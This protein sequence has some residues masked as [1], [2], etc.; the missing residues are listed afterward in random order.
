MALPGAMA[1]ALSSP[2]IN[3]T[4]PTTPV[5]AS[6]KAKLNTMMTTL[7]SGKAALDSYAAKPAASP[8]TSGTIVNQ[9]KGFTT[10]RNGNETKTVQTGQ[11]DTEAPQDSQTPEQVPNKNLQPGAQGEDVKK[12][13]D[14]LV[15]HGYLTSEQVATGPGTYGKQTTAAVA[16]LQQEL[17]LNPG[18]ASGFYGPQTQQAQGMQQK[19]AAA[20]KQLSGSDAPNNPSEGLGAMQNATQDQN[21]TDPTLG[22][23]ASNLQPT[24]D[25]LNQVLKNNSNP[26]L[27]AISLQKEYTNLMQQYDVPELQADLMNVQK[28]MEGTEDDIRD[29]VTKTGGFAT[30]SQ[31]MALSAARNKVLLKNYNALASQHQAAQD[32]VN[33]MMKFATEDRSMAMQR[34]NLVASVSEHLASIENQKTQMGMTMEN[35][36][37]DDVNKIVTNIGYTGLA[38]QARGN[39]DMLGY[40]EHTLKLVPGSLSNPASLQQLETYRQQQLAQG[41]QKINISVGAG[42]GSTGIPSTA[43]D[44]QV[45]Y[46]K[47]TGTVPAFGYGVAG[48]SARNAFWNAVASSGEGTIAGASGNKAALAAATTA[49]R[50]QTNQYNAANT[51]LSTLDKQLSLLEQYSDKVDRSGTPAFNRYQLYMKGQLQGDPDTQALQNIVLTASNEFAKILSGSAASISGTTVSSAED[52]KKLLNANMTTAQMKAVIGV[53]RQE[54][55][56]RLQ[57]QKETMTQIQNDIK[58]INSGGSSYTQGKQSDSDFIEKSLSGQNIKYTDVINGATGNEIPAVNRSTGAV[59]YLQPNEFDSSQFIRL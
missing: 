57:S 53:M 38:A 9:G 50:N 28:V 27:Q 26:A 32:N 31:V 55:K 25:A 51:A 36:V 23:A 14:Y 17:G 58:N 40:Y 21:I 30:D 54:G 3:M 18:T 33:N 12:L 15:Q 16:K 13:Q 22:A 42:G 6:D 49:L 34:D 29:E 7:Q 24:M 46:Y 43:T 1:R 56:Y 44:A 4:T 35:R 2:P 37:S 45:E 41:Q 8:V 20:Y 52:A 48:Q 19:Y 47:T 10:Y 39:L 5:S 59:V 11:Q